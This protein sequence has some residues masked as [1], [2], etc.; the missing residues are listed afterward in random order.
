MGSSR[1]DLRP[2]P[3]LGRSGKRRFAASANESSTG[4]MGI[5]TEQADGHVWLLP[6]KQRLPFDDPFTPCIDGNLRAIVQVELAQD[7]AHMRFD[8]FFRYFKAFR[9]LHV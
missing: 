5:E 6:T 4:L 1:P 9:D 2:L 7:V 8:G 3:V